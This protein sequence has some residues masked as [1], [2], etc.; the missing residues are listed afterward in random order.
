MPPPPP[1]PANEENLNDDDE[2]VDVYFEAD[3]TTRSNKGS[4][5]DSHVHPPP[6]P[7]KA[8]L[9]INVSTAMQL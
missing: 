6:D 1:P 9:E 4:K 3:N 2:A 8:Q 5:E 7:I